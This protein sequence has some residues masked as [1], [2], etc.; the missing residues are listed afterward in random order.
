MRTL[1]FNGERWYVDSRSLWKRL[2]QWVVWVGGW[3]RANGKGWALSTTNGRGRLWLS[4][5]PVSF[6]GHRLTIY[7][8]WIG[9]GR[10]A[11]LVVNFR[12]RYA[13]LSVDGTPSGAYAWLW[14]LRASNHGLAPEARYALAVHE[15][16]RLSAAP[17]LTEARP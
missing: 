12:D 15:A 8:H 11:R 9:A 5:T 4:P 3:E 14:G 16:D 1:R 6:F 2:R 7:G 17:A 10:R 13:Y